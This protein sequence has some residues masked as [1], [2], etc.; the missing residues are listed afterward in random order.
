MEPDS[1]RPCSGS[2]NR[3]DLGPP[4]GFHTMK[5]ARALTEVIRLPGLGRQPY[6]RPEY[7]LLPFIMERLLKGVP[8][9]A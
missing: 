7:Y 3:E 4:R 1:N 5:A 9:S 6:C 2:D 8:L